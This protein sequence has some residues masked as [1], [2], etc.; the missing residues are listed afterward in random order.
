[1][2]RERRHENESSQ[3]Y[4]IDVFF[5]NSLLK[6]LAVEIHNCDLVNGHIFVKSP[7]RFVVFGSHFFFI[8][9]RRVISLLLFKLMEAVPNFC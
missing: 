5:N 1:M 9:P 2:P 4:E 7:F 6:E 8:G 3:N